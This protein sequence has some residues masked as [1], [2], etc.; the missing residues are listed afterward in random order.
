MSRVDVATGE[1]IGPDD[2]GYLSIE[3]AERDLMASLAVESDI[4]IRE[5]K[6][7]LCV[8]ERQL[9]RQKLTDEG[10]PYQNFNAYLKDMAR[11]LDAVGMGKVRSLQSWLTRFKVYVRQLDKPEE[12][13][14]QMGTHAELLLPAASRADA[15]SQLLDDDQETA[16]GT[17]FGK[18]RFASLVAE[19]EDHV[20]TDD[21]LLKWSVNDTKEFVA[22]QM[23]KPVTE[24]AR[25]A[26]ECKWV[27]QDK[28]KITNVGWW[29][30]ETFRYGS[31]DLIPIGHF[32]ILSKS[33]DVQGLGEDWRD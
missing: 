11:Q 8:A 12:W 27:G 19:V 30:N 20:L 29:V 4:K 18:E 9:Y 24:K 26:L 3:D 31:S 10:V 22:E 15:T 2:V 17:R 6:I 33:A 14:R 5:I 7:L 13:L 25:L 23:G 28:V 21:P 16:A 32:R 1:I